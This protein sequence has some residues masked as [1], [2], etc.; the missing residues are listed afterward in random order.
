MTPAGVHI[1]LPLSACR[2]GECGEIVQVDGDGAT[3][4]RLRELGIEPGAE[5]R[6]ARAGSPVIVHI[7]GARLCLRGDLADAVLLRVGGAAH[8]GGPA[9][10]LARFSEGLA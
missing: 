9:A 8:T 6:I 5:V 2:S 4:R 10:E 3:L 7:H 1:D